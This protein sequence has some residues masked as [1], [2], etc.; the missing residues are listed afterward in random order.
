MPIGNPKQLTFILCLLLILLARTIHTSQHD[1]SRPLQPFNDVGLALVTREPE[2]LIGLDCDLTELI[3]NR[4]LTLQPTR[5]V[6][7]FD[8]DLKVPSRLIR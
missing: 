6:L 5:S 3:T 2:H 1:R 4:D 8:Q 7:I